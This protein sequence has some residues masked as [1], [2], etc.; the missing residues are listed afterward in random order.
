[1]NLSETATLYVY[2]G[3]TQKLVA[4]ESLFYDYD[5]VKVQQIRRRLPRLSFI[6][7]RL[8]F[9]HTGLYLKMKLR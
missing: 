8:S 7:P 9:I 3:Q 1:M 2:S 5:L 4:H 6:L